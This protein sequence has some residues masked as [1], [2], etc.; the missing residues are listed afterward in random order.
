MKMKFTIPLFLGLV[1]L[2]MKASGK[3]ATY[4][5]ETADDGVVPELDLETLEDIHQLGEVK[6]S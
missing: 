1:L 4:L 5:V 6:V 3:P 2:T